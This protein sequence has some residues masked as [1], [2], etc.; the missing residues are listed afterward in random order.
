MSKLPANC[1]KQEIKNLFSNFGQ[2]YEVVI[3][4]KR[5][6]KHNI[7]A[8]VRFTNV[9]DKVLLEAKLHLKLKNY[10]LT[11]NLALY[12][13]GGNK[14]T[15][16][17][18]LTEISTKPSKPLNSAPKEIPTTTTQQGRSFKDALTNRPTPQ[19]IL[20]PKISIVL[21]ESVA[22][23]SWR[24]CSLVATAKDVKTLCSSPKLNSNPKI[25]YI[26]GLKLLLTFQNADAME[27]FLFLKESILG[28]LVL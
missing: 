3:P 11:V 26:G 28:S 19:T 1:N 9:T 24:L 25:S 7:F 15:L 22:S 17:G 4:K 6:N 2:V 5:D 12:D 14:V 8:F 10:T 23:L 13:K 20:T 16:P 21:K 27:D 18:Q